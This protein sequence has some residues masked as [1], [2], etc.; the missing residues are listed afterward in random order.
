[1]SKVYLND[2][3]YLYQFLNMHI[4]NNKTN[5]HIRH[6]KR[7]IITLYW[8][9]YYCSQKIRCKNCCIKVHNRGTDKEHTEYNEYV[10]S[11]GLR[12]NDLELVNT[13]EY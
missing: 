10:L 4:V 6:D 12:I 5:N 2:F 9:K 8:S 7:Q 1:M 13:I 11:A 3:V